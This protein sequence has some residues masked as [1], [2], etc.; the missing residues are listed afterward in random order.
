MALFNNIEPHI[1]ILT[2]HH[3]VITTRYKS[4][5]QLQLPG[6]PPVI[7]FSQDATQKTRT[8]SLEVLVVALTKAVE[9]K[10]MEVL[11]L[12]MEARDKAYE[13]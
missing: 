1:Q 13:D 2:V 11:R 8:E 6:G 4:F 7:M 12:A 5:M 3:D 10:E 9:D